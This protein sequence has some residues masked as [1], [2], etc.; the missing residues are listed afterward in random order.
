M[1]V[2]SNARRADVNARITDELTGAIKKS[3][4]EYR[5]PWHHYGSAFFRTANVVSGTGY[6]DVAC[7]LSGLRMRRAATPSTSVA[8]IANEVSEGR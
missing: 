1:S 6:L 4:G 7:S 3:T 8:C 5:A 2:Q